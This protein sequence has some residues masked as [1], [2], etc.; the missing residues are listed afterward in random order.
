[1]EIGE[2]NA[3]LYAGAG[4]TEDSNPILEWEETENKMDTLGC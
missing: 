3:V 1:M 2:K 4:I